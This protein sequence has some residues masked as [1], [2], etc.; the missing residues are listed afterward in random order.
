MSVWPDRKRPVRSYEGATLWSAASD[1]GPVNVSG[2]S[3][4][5]VRSIYV[6]ELANGT[7]RQFEGS[8]ERATKEFE[9][10]VRKQFRGAAAVERE[11]ARETTKEETVATKQ[12]QPRPQKL[13][14]LVY[15]RGNTAKVAMAFADE[16]AAYDAASVNAKALEVAGVDGE[17]TVDELE[18]RW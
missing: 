11:A 9:R 16:N 8:Q 12:E 3:G 7:R 2:K 15:K 1:S 4:A 14:A 10:W 18:V 6:G 17:W 13:W 5:G